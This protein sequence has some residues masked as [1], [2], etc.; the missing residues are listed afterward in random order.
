[1]AK[2]H[3]LFPRTVDGSRPVMQGSVRVGTPSRLSREQLQ[4]ALDRI[5]RAQGRPVTPQAGPGPIP[6]A[7]LRDVPAPVQT[8]PDRISRME[9]Q[10]TPLQARR[11]PASRETGSSRRRSDLIPLLQALSNRA[12]ARPPAPTAAPARRAE[13]EDAALHAAVRGSDAPVASVTRPAPEPACTL[14]PFQPDQRAALEDLLAVIA[15][16]NRAA[17]DRLLQAEVMLNRVEQVARHGDPRPAAAPSSGRRML[18]TV[19]DLN[20]T[21]GVLLICSFWLGPLAAL[22]IVGYGMWGLGGY[23][24]LATVALAWCGSTDALVDRLAQAFDHPRLGFLRRLFPAAAA[25]RSPG[26]S[27]ADALVDFTLWAGA[28]EGVFLVWFLMAR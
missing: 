15:E 13:H 23:L 6:P 27:A 11:P 20:V 28:A 25:E 19:L 9:R 8:V 17:Q 2:I 16:Q 26:R 7:A 14:S 1:M 5:P 4:A 24:L 21:L 3:P 18:R 12:K 10:P 22:R